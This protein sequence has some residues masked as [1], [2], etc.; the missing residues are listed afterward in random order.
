MLLFEP[1]PTPCGTRAKLYSESVY[2]YYRDSERLPMVAIRTLL[3]QWFAEVP[4]SEQLDLAQRFRSPILRQHR[5]AL[6]ELYLHHLLVRSGFQVQFH[7]DVAGTQNHPDFLVLKDGT[8]R[9]YLEAIAVGNSAKEESEVN[10]I[11]QVYDTL[12]ALESPDFYVSVRVEGAPASSPAGA[13]LRKDLTKWLATLN[14]EEISASY[15]NEEIESIPA[16]EWNYDGWYVTFEPLPKPPEA[17]GSEG[18][19]AIGMTTDGKVRTLEL[20]RDLKEA[21]S[22]KD[23][24][25]A[26][27]LPFV[28]AIQVVD[29]HQIDR[30]DVINGLFGQA[31]VRLGQNRK[32]ILDRLRNGAWVAPGGSIHRTVSAVCVWSTLEPWNF[33]TLAPF[34]I[35]NPYAINPLQAD[36]LPWAQEIPDHSK[37][38]L[39]MQPGKPI[40]EVLGLAIDWLPED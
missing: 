34:T 1:S 18:V 35:H 5:S 21:V 4:A 14:W 28:H 16:Y 11:N 24:Y 27:T 13:K 2:A 12:N 10:R 20:D 17:R 3:E 39:I 22:K 36:L 33:V 25:G 30:N 40:A 6:F 23:R 9:F 37:N 15:I 8:A 32:Q 29:S 31:T 7:P 38:E 19:R 26:L